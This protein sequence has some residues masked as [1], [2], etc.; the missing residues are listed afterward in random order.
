MN[1]KRFAAIVCRNNALD[2]LAIVVVVC[3]ATGRAKRVGLQRGI[4][5][6]FPILDVAF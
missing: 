3:H 5:V 2:V 4:G 6:Y 1:T